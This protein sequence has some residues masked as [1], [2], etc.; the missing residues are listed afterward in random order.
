VLNRDSTILLVEPIYQGISNW[1]NGILNYKEGYMIKKLIFTIISIPILIFLLIIGAFIVSPMINNYRL[2]NF[3][4]QLSKYPL[5]QKT[6][7]LDSQSICGK[8]N[9]NGNG[10][11]FFSVIVIKSEL[12]L[13]EVKDYY[14]ISMK[15]AKRKGSHNVTLVVDYITGPTIESDLIENRDMSFSTLR[16][17][18]DFTGYYLVMIYDGGYQPDFDLRG[19]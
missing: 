9:G 16:K 1:L 7:I 4:E 11:D 2:N 10:M 17:V 15:P 18:T 13:D 19:N 5:P 3:E 12:E 6:S 8:L 14:N